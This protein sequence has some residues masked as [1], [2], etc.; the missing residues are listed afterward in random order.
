[1]M[2]FSFPDKLPVG[3]SQCLLGDNVRYDGSHKHS[4]IC[5]ELLARR[6][7]FIPVC[8]EMGIGM[9]A[10]REAIHLQG[11]PHDETVR[12]VG[13]RTATLDVT[14]KLEQYG[15]E[16]AAE[17][18]QLCGYI[19]MGRSPS[20]GL[21][22]IKVYHENG[23]PAGRSTQGIYAREFTRQHPLM[24]V[25]EE[26]RLRDDKLCENFVARVYAFKRWR[27][28][29]EGGLT[30][31]GLQAFH[32]RHKYLL[33]S[34][35]NESYRHLGRLVALAHQRDIEAAAHEYIHEFMATLKIVSTTKTHANVLQHIMG[36]L[37]KDLDAPSKQELLKLVDAY[38]CGQVPLIAPLTLLKHHLQRHPNA[39]LQQQFYLEPHPPELMLRNFH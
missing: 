6:F 30:H 29:T 15:R 27:D 22:S 24:P 5:T 12:A 4:K 31:A 32:A 19:F 1:M 38:R 39:Y 18:Q 26:G 7:D 34:H 2:D 17:L 13:N 11:N 33:M 23:N 8:P 25:E 3:I 35:R 37:K 14:D 16:K 28:L 20:C 9:N 21:G 36:Y 10:P